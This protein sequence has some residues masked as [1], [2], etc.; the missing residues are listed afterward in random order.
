MNGRNGRKEG[1]NRIEGRR[2]G[3]EGMTGMIK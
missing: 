2:A 1:K 3:M